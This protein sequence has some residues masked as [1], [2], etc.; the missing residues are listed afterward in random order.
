MDNANLTPVQMLNILH[1]VLLCSDKQLNPLFG[2]VK[3]KEQ[4]YT[5][6]TRVVL[7]RVHG[8]ASPRWAS[9]E[10]RNLLV[11]LGAYGCYKEYPPQ[12]MCDNSLDGFVSFT[13]RVF[14]L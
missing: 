10:A 3:L 12:G 13:H 4:L 9:E 1:A 11:H 7:A 6:L 5:R 14:G 2:G 8:S